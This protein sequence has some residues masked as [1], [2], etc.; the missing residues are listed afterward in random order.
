MLGFRKFLIANKFMD[1]KGGVS[2][3]SV[4]I[5]CLTVPKIFVGEHFR[6]SLISGIPKVL[7]LRGLCH[8]FH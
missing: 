2:R 4:E 1:K 3:S 6:M 5:F 7:C 8:I